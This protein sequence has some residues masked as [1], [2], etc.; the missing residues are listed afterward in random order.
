MS[1][2]RRFECRLV[3]LAE[4][5]SSSRSWYEEREIP[6][7]FRSAKRSAWS[8]CSSGI[9][10]AVRQRS[11]PP[12]AI[13]PMIICCLKLFQFASWNWY[14]LKRKRVFGLVFFRGI[15]VDDLSEGSK[16]IAEPRREPCGLFK[17]S[18]IF[19]CHWWNLRSSL[20]VDV[21]SGDVKYLKIARGKNGNAL[22]LAEK[23]LAYTSKRYT[24][25]QEIVFE[26]V[27]V[28]VSKKM[29]VIW[30]TLSLTPKK[31]H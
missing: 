14:N 31:I 16:S 8:L 15:I 26:K 20:H 10:P 18:T 2:E 12:G 11:K 9:L 13:L 30:G 23:S 3:S 28:L 7:I 21:P 4:R 24:F 1:H 6:P 25:V 22:C 29:V 17:L 5:E 19:H 27:F